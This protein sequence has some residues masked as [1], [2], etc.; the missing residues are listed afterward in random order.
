MMSPLFS[1]FLVMV[2]MFVFSMMLLASPSI[3]LGTT[4]ISV[5]IV[6]AAMLLVWWGLIESAGL[7]LFR[8]MK[9]AAGPFSCALNA[10]MTRVVISVLDMIFFGAGFGIVL[11]RT[12]AVTAAR[13]TMRRVSIVVF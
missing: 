12:V 8:I 2:S 11:A 9:T 4:A 1:F 7:V 6:L 10:I 13:T 5:T 3:V